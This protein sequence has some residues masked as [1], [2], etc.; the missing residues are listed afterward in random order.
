MSKNDAFVL[1]RSFPAT[2]DAPFSMPY[3]YLLYAERGALR[4]AAEGR[5][6]TLPPA[7]AALIAAH[8]EIRIAI[9]QEV[10]AC[11]ALFAPDFAAAPAD[12]LSVFEVSPLARELLF[13]LRGFG[14]TDALDAHAETLFRALA[15]EVQ[16]LARSPSPTALPQPKSRLLVQAME[17]MEADLEQGPSHEA[18]AAQL[19]VTPRTLSRRFSSE[20]GMTRRETLKRMRIIRAVEQ[21]A[22]D[23]DAITTIAMNVGYR[24]LSAFNSAFRD[25]TGEA[26][27][28]FRPRVRHQR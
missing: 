6:W 5:Q 11:S 21:I 27:G 14:E 10:T 18:L 16:R 19:A 13:S 24:S 2:P 20:M 17:I 28:A 3:H 25:I 7:R 9:P 22:A 1:S 12:T 26:P 15:S 8:S 4:L 23:E